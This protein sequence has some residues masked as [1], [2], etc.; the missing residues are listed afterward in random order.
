MLRAGFED[1]NKWILNLLEPLY[2][3]VPKVIG[4]NS[5]ATKMLNKPLLEIGLRTI[6]VMVDHRVLKV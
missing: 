1:V 2:I 4:F 3:L 6:L 5:G